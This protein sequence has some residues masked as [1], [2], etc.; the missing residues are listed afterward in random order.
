MS[1]GLTAAD[2][3]IRNIVCPKCRMPAKVYELKA[4]GDNFLVCRWPTCAV[5]TME[6]IYNCIWKSLTESQ[7][8]NVRRLRNETTAAA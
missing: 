8:D 6:G 3:T 1:E 5:G 2:F 4:T 7:K